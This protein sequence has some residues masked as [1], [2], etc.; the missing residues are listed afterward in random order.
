MSIPIQRF[1]VPVAIAENDK[2]EELKPRPKWLWARHRLPVQFAAWGEA[3]ND[4]LFCSVV[5]DTAV[6]L[7]GG[8]DLGRGKAVCGITGL[9]L[10]HRRIELALLGILDHAVLDVVVRIACT[11]HGSVQHAPLLARQRILRLYLTDPDGEER[12]TRPV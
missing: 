4:R 1:E 2:P 9:A 5:N 7:L 10:E 6:D 11:E 12:S 8:F 3:G